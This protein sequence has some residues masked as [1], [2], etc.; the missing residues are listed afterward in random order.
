MVLIKQG[1]LGEMIFQQFRLVSGRRELLKW[2]RN[3]VSQA[4]KTG[5][6]CVLSERLRILI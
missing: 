3:E 5:A 6:L 4:E 1:V 2:K